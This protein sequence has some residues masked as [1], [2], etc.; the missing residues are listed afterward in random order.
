MSQEFEEEEDKKWA[1]SSLE[2]SMDESSK[3]DDDDDGDSMNGDVQSIDSSEKSSQWMVTGTMSMQDI[4]KIDARVI[5]SMDTLQELMIAAL[6]GKK[7]NKIT[8][9]D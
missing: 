9:K 1:K 6:I 8:N 3:H 4:Q 7:Q 5:D 2:D